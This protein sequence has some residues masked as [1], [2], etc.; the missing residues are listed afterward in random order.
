MYIYIYIYI[1]I[2]VYTQK[3]VYVYTYTHTHTHTHTHTNTHTHTPIYTHTYIQ[4]HTPT[5]TLAP[6]SWS[7]AAP[8]GMGAASR[9]SRSNCAHTISTAGQ[10]ARASAPRISASLSPSN[11][12]LNSPHAL[13]TTPSAYAAVCAEMVAEGCWACG[14]EER[15]RDMTA[16]AAEISER[17]SLTLQCASRASVLGLHAMRSGV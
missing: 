1:Y 11:T 3:C 2:Y 12:T 14:Q 8:N 6:S 15:G 5:N 13:L 10:T 16:C 9:G 7:N 17:N 4:I